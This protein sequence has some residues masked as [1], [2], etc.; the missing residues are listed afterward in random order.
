MFVVVGFLGENWGPIS[1][2][3][4]VL[5]GFDCGWMMWAADWCGW[6]LEVERFGF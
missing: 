4:W 1:W 3:M 2:W 5:I 6:R